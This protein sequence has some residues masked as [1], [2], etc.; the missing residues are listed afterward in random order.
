MFLQR[1]DMLL[2]HM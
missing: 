1:G 2:H